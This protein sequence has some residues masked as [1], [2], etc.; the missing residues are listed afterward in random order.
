M[1]LELQYYYGFIDISIDDSTPSQFNRSL[2]LTVGIPIGKGKHD[3]K[4]Q[5]AKTGE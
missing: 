1:N 4:E 2:Y 5:A 3:K